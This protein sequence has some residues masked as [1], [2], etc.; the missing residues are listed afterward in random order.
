MADDLGFQEDV[1]FT[2]D[3]QAGTPAPQDQ[4]LLG[5]VANSA[6]VNFTLGFGDSVRNQLG[7]L[8]SL[9][10]GVN[11]APTQSSSGAAYNLGDWEGK[12]LPLGFGLASGGAAAMP[13]TEG[14]ALSAIRNSGPVQ[15]ALGHFQPGKMASK[16]MEALGQGAPTSEE[17]ISNIM[18]HIQNAHQ[19]NESSALE[20]KKNVLDAVGDK[21]MPS[22]AYNAA[23]E[24][25]KYSD[26]DLA[27]LHENFVN[28]P[29]F[30]NADVLQSQLGNEI[31]YYQKLAD[32]GILDTPK[33]IELK[34]IKDLRDSLNSDQSDFL[35]DTSP[36]LNNQYEDFKTQW[37]QNVVPYSSSDLLR[38]ITQRRTIDGQRTYINQGGVT[39]SEIH[40][41]FSFPDNDYKKVAQDIG[42]QGRNAILYNKFNDLPPENGD[43]L[44][45]QISEMER[46]GGYQSYM[47][48][49][50]K[51]NALQIKN[52]SLLKNALST[53]GSAGA[54]AIG[55]TL[56]GNPLLG[57]LG[58]AGIAGSRMMMNKLVMNKMNQQLLNKLVEPAL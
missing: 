42:E 46:R 11:V 35:K 4:S 10:P 3:E 34:K 44:A 1:G 43:L 32:K 23:T 49:E 45:N 16:T 14:N 38:Y 6:P 28:D 52:R 17:N 29:T 50:I 13:E 12:V 48:P 56:F 25:F 54:G 20:I 39:P 58:G 55:G 33:R 18:G 37:K 27:K 7:G 15:N 30:K 24:N 8:A 9:I 36:D 5:R 2:P 51:N 26:P 57:A 21:Q 53:I 31:G 22:D 40:S 19:Q 41:G 47:T